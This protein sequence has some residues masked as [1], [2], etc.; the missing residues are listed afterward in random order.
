MCAALPLFKGAVAGSVA[1]FD[2]RDEGERAAATEALRLM[3][4][5]CSEA[6]PIV[7][8]GKTWEASFGVLPPCSLSGGAFRIGFHGLSLWTHCSSAVLSSALHT[9]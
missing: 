2:W 1:E 7:M 4:G 3:L 6:Q 5:G 8:R 9:Q